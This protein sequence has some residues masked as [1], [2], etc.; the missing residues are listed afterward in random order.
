MIPLETSEPSAS[1]RPTRLVVSEPAE[2]ERP[3]NES[4]AYPPREPPRAES[5]AAS[6]LCLP[7]VALRR[8]AAAA[9]HP[10]SMA[11]QALVSRQTQAD[12]LS[13]LLQALPFFPSVS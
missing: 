8:D 1:G 12:P 13:D 7:V 10:V 11:W 4:A 2:Q 9:S 6:E 5:S 3:D